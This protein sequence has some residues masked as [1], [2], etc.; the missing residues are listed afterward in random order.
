MDCRL[1][2]PRDQNGSR[3]QVKEAAVLPC[4]GGAKDDC[5]KDRRFSTQFM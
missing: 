1:A 3:Q 2:N 5:G 4:S